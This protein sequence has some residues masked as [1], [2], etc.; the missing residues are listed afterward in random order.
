[1]TAAKM[2]AMTGL[3]I[4]PEKTFSWEAP[5]NLPESFDIRER[6]PEAA[7][8]VRHQQHCGSCWAF[9]TTT[10]A[11]IR[12]NI[13][14]H[15]YGVLSPQDLVSCDK[16][17]AACRGGGF[18]TPHAH[19][20]ETGATTEECMSYKSFA[21]RV[22]TCPSKCDNGSEIIRHK[23][24]SIAQ[25][26]V[27]NVMEGLMNDGPMF[28]AFTV[29]EDFGFYRS[30]IYKHKYGK[31]ED[32]HAVTLIGWGEENGEKYWLLQ[33]SWGPEWGENGFF[34]MRRGTNEC[35]CESYGFISG[36][37]E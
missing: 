25:Y 20:L 22:P 32:G 18:Y 27:D 12:L 6:Y 10:A 19:M 8:P 13:K 15:N 21:G 4:I 3:P 14:G 36:L 29:Y 24:K 35:G 5:A 37:V 31:A 26:T 7:V 16:Y 2:R 23:Y 1:M 17:D 30:G 28:F 33:N 34:R 11:S 9:A